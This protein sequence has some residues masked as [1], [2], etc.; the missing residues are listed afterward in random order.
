VRNAVA[1][2]DIELP[3]AIRMA[4]A[5]P[6]QVLGLEDQKGQIEAGFDADLVVLNGALEMELTW[7][8]GHCVY[9]SGAQ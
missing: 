6:A 2:L 7:I 8:A 1:M 5:N 9:E 4:S 3:Q